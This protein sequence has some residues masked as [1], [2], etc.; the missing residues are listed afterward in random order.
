[1]SGDKPHHMDAIVKTITPI[2]N[3][4]RRPNKSPI[5]PPTRMSAPRSKPYDSITHCASITVAPRLDWRAGNATFTIVL[6]MK[7]MLD[8]RMAAARIHVP[9][10]GG[11]SAAEGPDRMASS[12]QGCLMVANDDQA[13]GESSQDCRE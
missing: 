13:I 11:L 5:E 9:A 7:A 8:A 1:M 10:A 2:R 6:S 12:S 4:R 3:A